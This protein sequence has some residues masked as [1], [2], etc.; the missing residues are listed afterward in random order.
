[1]ALVEVIMISNDQ[2]L[3]RTFGMKFEQFD[4]IRTI[5][6]ILPI[7]QRSSMYFES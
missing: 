7:P 6:R 3:F 1:M 5:P 2:S 4:E